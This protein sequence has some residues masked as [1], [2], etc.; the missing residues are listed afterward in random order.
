MLKT[1]QQLGKQ[2]GRHWFQEKI[3]L[4][5]HVSETNDVQAVG[6]DSTGINL[7][8]AIPAAE[9]YAA[10][11]YI[12]PSFLFTEKCRFTVMSF[13]HFHQNDLD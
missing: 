13:M 1:V 11:S 10:I 4:I 9:S 8:A 2:G 12:S 6:N 3:D 7:P 5:R